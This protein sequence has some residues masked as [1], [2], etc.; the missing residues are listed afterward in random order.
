MASPDDTPD[1][2]ASA[3]PAAFEPRK[4][5]AEYLA[6]GGPVGPVRLAFRVALVLLA[7]VAVDAW[8]VRFVDEAA[9]AGAY[10]VPRTSPTAWLPGYATAV[11]ARAAASDDLRVTF[12]GASPAWGQRIKDVRSGYPYSFAAAASRAGVKVR[13][14]NLAC[15]GQLVG[16]ELVVAHRVSPGSD[17]VFVELT[18]HTFNPAAST[19]AAMRYP[20]LPDLLGVALSP[21]EARALGAAPPKPVDLSV[22]IGRVLEQRWALYR[23]RTA[24]AARLFGGTP[25]GQLRASW[26]RLRTGRAPVDEETPPTKADFISFADQEPERVT[27]IVGSY[28]ENASFTVDPGGPNLTRLRLLARE[29]RSQGV[30]AVF[31]VAP[32][33]REAV[34]QFELIDPAVYRRNADRIG[35]VVREEGFPFLDYN[36]GPV[37][38]GMLYFADIS[39]TTDLG[40][41]AFG[42]M[43]F[44]DTEA[45]LRGGPSSSIATAGIP[46]RDASDPTMTPPDQ[47]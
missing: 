21:P 16:D 1:D 37:R 39:H 45:Y 46:A 26:T 35:S 14:A 12:L 4:R 5:S 36:R 11:N 44:R 43:L 41:R 40:G 6:F 24:V 2:G 42:S 19:G 30:R 28:A 15:N 17:V 31:Y 25:D 3:D 8:V 47:P 33:N 29:L 27:L 38:L 18:Y 9:F 23:D 32:L 10:R 34:E 22:P 13:S 7:L 20:E